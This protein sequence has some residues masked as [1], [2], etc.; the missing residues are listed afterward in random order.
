MTLTDRDIML[1][2]DNTVRLR[3]SFFV[4][5]ITTREM[6]TTRRALATA[7][8]T[9]RAIGSH[10]VASDGQYDLHIFEKHLISPISY[11]FEVYGSSSCRGYWTYDAAAEKRPFNPLHMTQLLKKK[12]QKATAEMVPGVRL[13]A[14]AQP[15]IVV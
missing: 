5:V 3:P 1:L 4:D 10:L 11:P 6:F 14:I 9:H 12:D 8:K 15:P 2:D 13:L 7:H